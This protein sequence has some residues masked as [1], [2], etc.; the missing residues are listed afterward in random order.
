MVT[1]ASHVLKD[2]LATKTALGFYKDYKEHVENSELI[3]PYLQPFKTHK[4]KVR[5]KTHKVVILL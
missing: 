1:A 4:S 2:V 5:I 3:I